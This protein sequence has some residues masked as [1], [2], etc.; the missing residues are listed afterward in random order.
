MIDMTVELIAPYVEKDPTAF[1]SYKEFEL[2]I[3]ALQEFCL[4]RAES[5]QGQ[6]DGI[7]PSTD[8]GQTADIMSL[9]DAS[10]LNLSDMGSM[11]NGGMEQ[12]G[13][14]REMFGGRGNRR[15]QA[16]GDGESLRIPGGGDIPDMQ[17]DFGGQEYF[18]DKIQIPEQGRGQN[19]MG[20]SSRR[21]ENQFML[22]GV[23]ILFLLAGILIA[24]KV[25]H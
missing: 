20:S 25:K 2:G 5:I 13:S 16:A 19:G 3:A 23:S 18:S 9:I 21:G 15:N 6:I 1:Y 11:F 7:I 22:V 8:E 12:G 24:L 10:A 14:F 4:L 17:R